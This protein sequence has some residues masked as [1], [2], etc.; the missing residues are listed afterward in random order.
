MILSDLKD[1]II[2]RKNLSLGKKMVVVMIVKKP[3]TR[4]YM[5]QIVLSSV[6]SISVCD[7]SASHMTVN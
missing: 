7:A 4:S 3:E 1:I 2:W 6:Y 5:L